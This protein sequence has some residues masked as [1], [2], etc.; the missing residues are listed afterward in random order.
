MIRGSNGS[1]RI[2]IFRININQ[3]LGAFLVFCWLIRYCFWRPAE[4]NKARDDAE[5]NAASPV[6][7]D[8]WILH[9]GVTY[10]LVY[11][12]WGKGGGCIPRWPRLVDQ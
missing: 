2:P 1:Y 4:G 5:A 11:F 7:I 3:Q 6:E 12:F 10:A 8:M 9:S